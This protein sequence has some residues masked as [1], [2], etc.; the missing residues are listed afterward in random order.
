[1]SKF[2]SPK[3]M[4]RYTFI[5]ILMTLVAVAVI[6]K[7]LYI[8]TAKRD[9]W[10]A[11]ADRQK[12]DSVSVKPMRGNI[13]S[14]DEQLMAST[15]PEYKLYMDFNALY[16]AKNDSLW[17]AKLDSICN[18]LHNIFPEKSAAS[19]RRHLEEGRNKLSRHWLL[20]DKR[21]DYN[22]FT[23]VRA[24]PVFRLPKFKSGF[25]TEE[26]NARQ[27]PY[28][29]LA[30]RTVGDMYG[31]K[32]T[33][34][35][36]LE[37]SYDSILRGSNGIIH[38][39]KVLN[40]F[41]DIMDTPPIDGADIVT[42]IDV[43]MQDLAERSLLDEMKEINA[44]VGVVLVME[45][46]TGDVKAIVNM[47]RCSDGQYREVKNHAVSDL[48]EPGS[49]FKV[50]S[51]M[52]AIDDGVVDTAYKVNTGGG[53]WP[54][55]GR[56]MRDHNWR[57]GGYGVLSV[58]R[59]LEVS[60]NIGISRVIDQYYHNNPEKFVRGI[61]RLGLAL[62]FQIPLV[63]SSPAKIRMP[64]KAPNGQW[65][66]WSN[67][68]LPWMSIGYETQI[69]PI[70]TLTFYNAIANGGRMMQPRFVKAAVM[71]GDTIAEFPPE[72]V[73]GREQ[74]ASEKTIKII[75]DLLRRV[76]VKGTGKRANTPNFYICGKT[77][78]AMIARNGSYKGMPNHLLS[79]AGWFGTKEK[80]LYS[81]IVCIQKTGI[82]AFGWMSAEAFRDIAE[83]IMAKYV[84]YD[85]SGARDSSSVPIPDVKAGNI[86]SADY[87]LS[88]L[89]INTHTNFTSN[90]NVSK[91]VWGIAERRKGSVMLQKK[92]DMGTRYMPNVIG[93]GARDAV[94]LIEKRGVK[95]K[96]KGR[97]K[98]SGQSLEAGHFIK[99]GEV[100]VLT[101]D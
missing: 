88:R 51:I 20:W 13:L 37:L 67:T 84:K 77:G 40:K 41:L 66:N 69:P 73:K 64:K 14:C 55:Y 97:G 9:Y 30:G 12:K 93:M 22:T 47:E 4:P 48:L 83:G 28:G 76:V 10:M 2:D 100:C 63:G 89:G 34:R 90:F 50:A 85:I 23:E 98:V 5:T 49:V 86:L 24:L 56:E 81:C 92:N 59:S 15:L 101:L 53:T 62:D 94:Y 42:T 82:P 29:S 95:C 46:A 71:N 19:F 35:F 65:L 11:V 18:G 68:A 70:Y 38:R 87:V 17:T 58:S 79:F 39:R 43:N 26:Y 6:G 60:S 74:I 33:A 91:P 61:Y 3:I 36:G 21:V 96:L 72:V 31:A 1:M 7:T 99:K 32:D 80:P 8:M 45:V 44:H 75:Q 16:E 52:T 78:T 27:R 57:R 54:M 25:H